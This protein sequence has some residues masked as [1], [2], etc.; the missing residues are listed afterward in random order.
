M[1]VSLKSCFLYEKKIAIR[2]VYF[3]P[4]FSSLQ[5]TTIISALIFP[6][7]KLK[8]IIT[9]DLKTVDKF[10][11]HICNKHIMLINTWKKIEREKISQ[12]INPSTH[13]PTQKK[14]ARQLEEAWDFLDV[15]VLYIMF[16]VMWSNFGNDC[17]VY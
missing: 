9:F 12:P 2:A 3:C 11:R 16:C 8:S 7:F 14:N 6:N 4:L 13:P 1:F 15:F 17:Y 10:W 5:F